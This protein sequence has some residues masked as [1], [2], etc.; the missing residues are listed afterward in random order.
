M[1]EAAQHNS[2][3]LLKG[4]LGRLRHCNPANRTSAAIKA[5]QPA[6]A[7]GEDLRPTDQTRPLL[8]VAAGGESSDPG[9]VWRHA[10]EGG[11]AAVAGGIGDG[12]SR[13]DFGDHK[14]EGGR[15]VRKLLD[16]RYFQG[17][18]RR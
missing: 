11:G 18:S 10:G 2:Q 6:T 17:S 9:A 15:Y 12:P 1:A 4:P 14:R 16:K 5:N 7:A 8:L 3:D 13:A